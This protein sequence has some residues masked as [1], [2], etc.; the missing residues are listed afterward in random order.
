MLIFKIII[1]LTITSSLFT[2]SLLAMERVLPE[3]K[4]LLKEP[5]SKEP[6]SINN[7]ISKKEYLKKDNSWDFLLKSTETLKKIIVDIYTQ[8][9]ESIYNFNKSIKDIKNMGWYNFP[10][11]SFYFLEK[12]ETGYN[13]YYSKDDFIRFIYIYYNGS[14]VAIQ[15]II[16]CINNIIEYNKNIIIEYNKNSLSGK[17][18]NIEIPKK[19]KDELDDL[20]FLISKYKK[21]D[22]Y[23]GKMCLENK[24]NKYRK[25]C[26]L[27]NKQYCKKKKN[28]KS[29][30]I[31]E[32]FEELCNFN[33][34]KDVKLCTKKP[35][36]SN[37]S[38]I[39]DDISLI[40]NNIKDIEHDIQKIYSIYKNREINKFHS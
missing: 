17:K 4:Y 10:I 7:Q 12:D 8:Y 37:F 21:L 36:I 26:F 29:S 38:L 31:N 20:Y 14:L 33:G 40:K 9:N 28:T 11:K 16:K 27:K 5:L 22:C 30:Y 39:N 19:I 35:D 18:I 32:K 3:E 6:F 34:I 1:A 2:S 15:D 25:D 24:Y 23:S 13:P